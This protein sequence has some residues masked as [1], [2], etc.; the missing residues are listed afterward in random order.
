MKIASFFAGIGGID[1]AFERAGFETVWANE[2]DGHAAETYRANFDSPLLVED[3]HKVQAEDI[4]DFDVLAGGFP[5]QSFSV[6]GRRKG[7]S[8][9]RGNLFFELERIF[10][11]KRPRAIFLENVK[12]LVSHDH[13]NTFRVIKERLEAAGYSVAWKV[14][15]A[16]AYG[17]VPQNRE[18]IYIC[19]FREPAAFGHFNFPEPVPLSAKLA[20]F[21]DFRGRKDSALY[22]VPER[23]GRYEDLAAAVTSRNTVYQWRRMYVR[24]NKSGVCPTLTANMGG[25]GHNVPLVLTAH[26]IRKLTPRECFRIMGFPETFILPD[27]AACHLYKQAGNSVAV[28]VVRRI[29]ECMLKALEEAG[30]PLLEEAPARPS[31]CK[32]APALRPRLSVPVMPVDARRHGAFW[33]RSSERRASTRNRR[34]PMAKA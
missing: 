20:D 1:L 27:M 28:P 8:D 18:R 11:A 23:F 22:Y 10:L 29:A 15:N 21:V 31:L 32:E 13:G 9:E 24:E 16:C 14:L 30:A 33:A 4:P 3:I 2:F 26:G 6:A 7:F 19:A 17:N 34:R 25:G 5:C 12:N